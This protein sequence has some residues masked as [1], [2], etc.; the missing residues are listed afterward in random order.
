MA[1]SLSSGNFFMASMQCRSHRDDIATVHVNSRE[2]L[3]QHWISS[4]CV[5]CRPIVHNFG[6]LAFHSQNS[7][8][9][10]SDCVQL[11]AS[12]YL[13]EFI[14]HLS[15]LSKPH[16]VTM[17]FSDLSEDS[18]HPGDSNSPCDLRTPPTE[19]QRLS[20]LVK[21]TFIVDKRAGAP[22]VSS[23]RVL[24]HTM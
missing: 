17:T 14:D 8:H 20:A 11:G 18:Y 21:V 16:D 12:Q 24:Q 3:P 22:R 9:Q 2:D 23:G 13:F 10:I 4:L 7:L 19:C 6:L 15:K 1:L 5:S